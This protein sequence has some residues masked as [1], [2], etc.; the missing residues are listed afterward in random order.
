M[1]VLLLTLF[2]TQCESDDPAILSTDEIISQ[3]ENI[4]ES[5]DWEI[6]YFYDTDS[7]ETTNYSGYTFTFDNTGS[8]TA[9]NGS[10]TYTGTWSVIDDSSSDDSSDDIDFNIFFYNPANFAELSDDWGIV[11]HTSAKIELIDISGGNGETD[12]LTFEKIE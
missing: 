2:S 1:G 5:G 10:N 8:L 7:D 3:I 4:V 12:Y 6:T 9:T 11:S